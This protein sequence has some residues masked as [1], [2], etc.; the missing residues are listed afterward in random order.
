M[1]SSAL[2]TLDA[3]QSAVVAQVQRTV[4]DDASRDRHLSEREKAKLAT[5]VEMTA[6]RRVRL[7]L[8]FDAADLH[9]EAMT[10][11]EALATSL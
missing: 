10:T 9:V 11:I 4:Y 1:T 2:P 5:I 7:G 6:V 3:A 8:P